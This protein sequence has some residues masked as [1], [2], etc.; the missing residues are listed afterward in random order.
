VKNDAIYLRFILDCLRWVE[1]FSA[2]GRDVFFSDRRT[3]DAI[4]RNLQVLAEATQR[5]SPELREM[6]D[7]VFW[8]GIGG[9]RNVLVHNY[10][11]IISGRSLN[12]TSLRYA[13]RLKRCWRRY[14]TR[15]TVRQTRMDR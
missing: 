14:G 4:L 2:D 11:G 10:L 3:R 1:S 5:L 13:D 9:L 7:D 8:R 6:H 15:T 12:G